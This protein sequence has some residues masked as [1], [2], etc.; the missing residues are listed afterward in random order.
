MENKLVQRD[1]N[2]LN[3]G[4]KHLI[5]QC[6][7]MKNTHQ[8][9]QLKGLREILYKRLCCSFEVNYFKGLLFTGRSVL[10]FCLDFI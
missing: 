4:F 1:H 9:L 2:P 3:R 7:L 8:M 5:D 10:V 6:S